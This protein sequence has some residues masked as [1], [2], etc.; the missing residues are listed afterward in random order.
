MSTPGLTADST[1]A[2]PRRLKESFASIP[3]SDYV[4]D[5]VAVVTLGLSLTAP[6]LARQDGARTGGEMPAFLLA[7]VVSFLVLTLPYLARLGVL[8]GGWT[9]TTTRIVRRLSTVPFVGFVVWAVID[10]L[11]VDELTLFGLAFLFAGVGTALAAQTRA[12]ELGPI[13]KDTGPTQNVRLAVIIALGGVVALGLLTLI[14][15]AMTE[16]VSGDIKTVFILAL[17][18]ALAIAVAPFVLAAVRFS[19]GWRRVV[20]AVGVSW[21]VLAHFADPATNSLPSDFAVDMIFPG[22]ILPMSLIYGVFFL[23]LPAVA[24]LISSPAWERRT[25]RREE[26]A[27]NIEEITGLLGVLVWW[28]AG[29]LL[30]YVL[31][32]TISGESLGQDQGAGQLV[33]VIVGAGAVLAAGALALR[34]LRAKGA[35]AR[36]AIIIAL[37]VSLIGG[38]VLANASPQ[39][40]GMSLAHLMFILVFP[41]LGLIAVFGHSGARE[42][43]RS[44]AAQR[45]VNADAYTWSE[46]MLPVVAP[47][48]QPAA[49]VATA[50]STSQEHPTG[51]SA[52]QPTTA[53]HG[54]QAPAV[55]VGTSSPSQQSA[56]ETQVIPRSSG[57]DQGTPVDST[58]VMRPVSPHSTPSVDDSRPNT[59]DTQSLTREEV[60][61]VA[62]SVPAADAHS[63]TW[64]Q[65]QDPS[66]D[67]VV[68]ARIAEVAPELRPALAANPAT[69]DAL[70]QWLASVGDP[71]IDAALARRGTSTK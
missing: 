58:A 47:A 26:P 9:V 42:Y 63:Y 51:A 14:V 4:R 49:H 23:F 21:L 59:A 57:T 19:A 10:A 44:G 62:Q 33:Q 45:P 7:V 68:L 70:L 28:A 16:G 8:P 46:R 24:A 40:W 13:D 5:A 60:L 15:S 20:I 66:T 69:Y 55:S 61:S 38:V 12:S 50:Y 64:E 1:S 35:A 6:L 56:H 25:T 27:V 54:T 48:Q 71:D 52:H 39:G 34:S 43:F 11:L 3:E 37:A 41:V 31:V 18:I 32:F 22:G 30:I 36:P 2:E 17:V 65:A 53:G 67:P 29:Y